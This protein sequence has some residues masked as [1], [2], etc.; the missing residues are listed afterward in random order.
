MRYSRAVLRHMDCPV[1]IFQSTLDRAIQADCGRLVYE[2]AGC[3]DEEL[4]ILHNSGHN[5]T[6]DSEREIVARNTHRFI[7]EH[8]PQ[9]G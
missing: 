2:K 5:L 1:L 4:V 6:M 8:L 3:S 9:E 7:E